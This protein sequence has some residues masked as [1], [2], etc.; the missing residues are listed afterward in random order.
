MTKSPDSSI[1]C[2]EARTLRRMPSEDADA[3]LDKSASAGRMGKAVEYLVAAACI[4]NTREELNVS[5]G[6]PGISR[7]VPAKGF[8]LLPA[9]GPGFRD[10]RW[11]WG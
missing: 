5:T 6:L 10:L 3:Y 11:W 8:T 4:L 9:R 7:T 1:P 2:G